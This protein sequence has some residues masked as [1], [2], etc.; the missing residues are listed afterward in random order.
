MTGFTGST[1]GRGPEDGAWQ[2]RL[3][4]A[5]QSAKSL[6]AFANL[7]SF[8]EEHLVGRHEIEVV[9]LIE[10]P[11]Q[12]E[13]DDVLA[14]PTLVRHHPE[15]RRKIIGDLSNTERVLTGLRLRSESSR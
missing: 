13:I 8:C 7:R 4:V 1:D 6:E 10:D 11:S 3:Y 9:D 12:A 5:G 15:P 14:I 2:L